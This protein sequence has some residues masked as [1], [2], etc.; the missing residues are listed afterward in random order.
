MPSDR[1]KRPITVGRS[2]ALKQ[3]TEVKSSTHIVVES[4]YMSFKQQNVPSF[5]SFALAAEQPSVE[6]VDHTTQDR[7][8]ADDEVQIVAQ[9]AEAQRFPWRSNK[10]VRSPFAAT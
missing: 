6:V 9:S 1:E 10:H 4:R 3:L 2:L 8:T 5:R 7:E